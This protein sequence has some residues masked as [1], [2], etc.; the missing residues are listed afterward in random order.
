[1]DAMIPIKRK[2][3]LWVFGLIVL[4]TTVLIY[5]VQTGERGLS[6]RS[7]PSR[8]LDVMRMGAAESKS[9]GWSPE[10]LNEVFTYASTLSS[11]TLMIVTKGRTVGAFGDLKKL[12]NVHSIRKAILSALVG[13]HVGPGTKQ[14]R[15][16][17]TLQDLG[18]DD[19]PGSLSNLQKQVRVEHLLKST[20]GINHPAAAGGGFVTETK[21]LLSHG[22]NKPGTRWAYNNW[23]YNVLTTIFETRTGTKIAEGFKTTIAQ[24]T[25]MKDFRTDAVSYINA[26]E[27][28]QHKAAIFRMSAR[29][30]TK[31]GQ[32]YL[33]KGWFND[34]QI[35]P[36]QWIDRITTDFTETGRDDLRWGHGYL[37]WIPAPEVGLPKGSYWAWGLGN[38]AV[39]VIPAW[40]TVITHQSDTTEFLE[41]FIPMITSGQEAETAIEQL[42]LSC[43]KRENRK[44]EYCIEHRFTT[45]RE[46]QKLISLVISARL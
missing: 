34:K 4:M 41:R 25:G 23:D 40:D 1:M 8:V 31:F 45:R 16:D 44:S 7:Q 12:H 2:V 37:W 20:S 5:L 35:I 14:I 29:D 24:P 27:R 19:T 30:L 38:Q 42:I 18:I 36:V 10:R 6:A 43:I 9:L 28:S 21:R 11:D 32:L 46:F 17:A 13:Q 39:F 33:E 15:L 26:P 3:L 22:E